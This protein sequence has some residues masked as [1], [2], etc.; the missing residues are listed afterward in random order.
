MRGRYPVVGS[1]FGGNV[2][3]SGEFI[4]E[5]AFGISQPRLRSPSVYP[6]V[7]LSAQQSARPAVAVG[8][9]E[10]ICMLWE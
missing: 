4:S 9:V 6:S 2:I 7:C 8:D 5:K 1:A 10:F 3:A